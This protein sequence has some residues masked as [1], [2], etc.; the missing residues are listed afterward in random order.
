MLLV[1][2]TFL[3]YFQAMFF[4]TVDQL[5]LDQFT[6]DQEG[7]LRAFQPARVMLSG[8][9]INHYQLLMFYFLIISFADARFECSIS[10][11]CTKCVQTTPQANLPL[12]SVAKR[13]TSFVSRNIPKSSWIPHSGI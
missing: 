8:D 5:Q 11:T 4:E 6:S 7:A 10:S 2:K 9:K 13:E 12:H 1:R 3:G